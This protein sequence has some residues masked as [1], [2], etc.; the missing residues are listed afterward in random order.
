MDSLKLTLFFTEKEQIEFLEKRAWVI[1]VK[2]TT[3]PIHRHGSSFYYQDR[4]VLYAKKADTEIE[5]SKAF[6]M[7]MKLKL[8]SE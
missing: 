1:C 8:L 4:T 3:C 6:E 2:I 7:E 5:V